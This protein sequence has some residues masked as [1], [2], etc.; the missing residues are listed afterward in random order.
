MSTPTVENDLLLLQNYVSLSF[1][2]GCS[3]LKTADAV[4]STLKRLVS[5]VQNSKPTQLTGGQA[6]SEETLAKIMS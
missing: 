5:Y 3:D 2:K 6:I 4:I 1:T